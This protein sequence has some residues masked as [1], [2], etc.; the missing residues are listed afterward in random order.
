M[1]KV[2]ARTGSNTY[3]IHIGYGML[4]RLGY[5]LKQNQVIDKLVIIIHPAV[6]PHG[7]GHG[8]TKS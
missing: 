5:W 6:E 7:Q 8:T 2:K 1:R 4:S 3:E